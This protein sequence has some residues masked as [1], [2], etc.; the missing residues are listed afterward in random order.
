MYNIC[1]C[2][3][4]VNVVFMNQVLTFLNWSWLF[5]IKLFKLYYWANNISFDM[6]STNLLHKIILKFKVWKA[7]KVN[8]WVLN[9]IHSV[10]GRGVVEMLILPGKQAMIS[11]QCIED[12]KFKTL[13]YFLQ[14][15]VSYLQKFKNSASY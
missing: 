13:N 10:K 9:C 2:L 6:A 3:D 1:E 15:S 7:K 4:P 8:C 5:V 14:F 11:K 12:A